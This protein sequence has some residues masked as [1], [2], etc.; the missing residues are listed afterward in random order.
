MVLT[1]LLSLLLAVMAQ[2]LGEVEAGR[3][4]RHFRNDARCQIPARCG[5]FEDHDL[6][7]LPPDVV[8]P[9]TWTRPGG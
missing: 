4:Q 5:S 1:S 2:G 7:T 9:L 8:L 3:H 6:W